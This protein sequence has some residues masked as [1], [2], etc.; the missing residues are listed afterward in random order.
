MMDAGDSSGRIRPRVGRVGTVVLATL[1]KGAMSAGRDDGTDIALG[2]G[3]R[4]TRDTPR[5]AKK[6]AER[7]ITRKLL[8][9]SREG[10]G[11][12]EKGERRTVDCSPGGG[13]KGAVKQEVAEGLR[14]PALQQTMTEKAMRVGRTAPAV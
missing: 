3:N 6:D 9:A 13:R 5:E 12:T 4:R 14:D 11:R 10:G 2:E 7:K 1:Q 8:C